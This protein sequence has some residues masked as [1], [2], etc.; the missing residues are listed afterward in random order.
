MNIGSS[1]EGVAENLCTRSFLADF[2]IR[3]PKYRKLNGQEKEAAD[4]LIVFK[5]TLLV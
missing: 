4:V 5:E 3:R 2:T 1:I